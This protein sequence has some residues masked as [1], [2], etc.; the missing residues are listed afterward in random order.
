MGA[1][2]KVR[3]ERR[4][5]VS[6]RMGEHPNKDARGRCELCCSVAGAPCNPGRARRQR[7]RSERAAALRGGA[8]SGRG[9]GRR[10]G[11]SIEGAW[12]NGGVA[13]VG[14][15]QVGGVARFAPPA[16]AN[17]VGIK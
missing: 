5:G 7:A 8:Q 6:W 17:G 12:L 16:A 3:D 9:R 1:D 11:L 14:R 2:R 4:H 15:G 10:R 13:K